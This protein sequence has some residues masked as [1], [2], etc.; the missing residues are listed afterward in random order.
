MRS[1]AFPWERLDE[2]REQVFD[3]IPTPWA[4]VENAFNR[5]LTDLGFGR[6]FTLEYVVDGKLA[7]LDLEVSAS[8]VHYES[9]PR[10][11]AEGIGLTV[12]DLTYDV[13]RYTQR[14]ADEP[15][16]VIS[17]IEAGSKASVAGVKPFEIITHVNDQPVANVKEF[18]AQIGKGGELRLS[19]KRMAKGRIVTLKAD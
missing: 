18:E 4:P 9:A 17:K 12:R 1:Q 2:I 10:Y 11:K 15:G 19:I 5:A 16:V 14:K 8:P 3:R 13:R 7:S 6:K